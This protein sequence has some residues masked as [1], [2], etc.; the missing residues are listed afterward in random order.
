MRKAF[1]FLM[2]MCPLD[3]FIEIIILSPLD[4]VTPLKLKQIANQKLLGLKG[5]SSRR[6][7]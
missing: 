4:S 7:P 6:I 2:T 3:Y 5:K 1:F